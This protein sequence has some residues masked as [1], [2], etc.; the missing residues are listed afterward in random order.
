MNILKRKKCKNDDEH[1]YAF[2][3]YNDNE[4]LEAIY[5]C[6]NCGK[7]VIEPSVRSELCQQL[8]Y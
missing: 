8:S 3:G 2:V 7:R 5:V 6:K 4:E 1:V